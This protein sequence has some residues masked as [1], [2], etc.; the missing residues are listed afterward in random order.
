MVTFGPVRTYG[1][2]VPCLVAGEDVEW[3]DVGRGGR[4][5][6]R[7]GEVRRGGNSWGRRWHSCGGARSHGIARCSFNNSVNV[8]VP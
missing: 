7:L 1:E 4:G 5:P 8:M 2:C 6:L 3:I